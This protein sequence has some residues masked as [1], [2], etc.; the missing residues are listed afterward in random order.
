M[1]RFPFVFQPR[2]FTS[3]KSYSRADFL[4]DLAAGTTVAIIAL[5]LAMAFGIASGAGP[6]QG[7]AAAIIGGFL[8][9]ALGGSKVQIGGPAGAF[10][11]L[12]YSIV[13]QHGIANL[14]I[15][16]IM[17]GVLLFA[18]G[19]MRLGNLIRFIPVSVVIG[20]TAGIAVII[21][22]S[23]VKDALGLAIPKMPANFFSQLAAIGGALQ[24]LNWMAAAIALLSLLLITLWPVAYRSYSSSWQRLAAKFPSTLLVLV[25]SA[26]A[27]WALDLPVE[28]IGGK[29]GALP[30]GLSAPHIPAFDWSTAQNLV[31]P[32][33][34]I[35]L[36][37]AI[38]SLLCARMADG[39][40]GDRHDPNQELMAQGIAN[41]FSPWFGGIAVTGTAARTVTNIR[42]GARSP[43][44][45]VVHAFVLLLILLLFAP[46]AQYIPLASLAAILLWVAY[47]MGQWREFAKLGQFSVFY[48]TTLLST[49]F[50]TVVF[51]LVVA[52]EVGLVLSSLFFIYR[53]SSLTRVD[54]IALPSGSARLASGRRVGAWKLVGSLFF[55]SV[56]KLEALLEPG[57]TLPDVVI[58]EMDHLL[59]L[60]TTGLEALVSLHRALEMRGGRLIVA[61]AHEQPLSLM[62][63]GEF[64]KTVGEENFLPSLGAALSLLA[65]R[66]LP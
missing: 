60:D 9:S 3:L 66:D 22:L 43:V 52:V 27:A 46:L 42:T 57:R 30:R 37:A 6:A 5:P 8:V 47:N 15:A 32:T 7:L 33:L 65:N 62:Q 64:V 29:F 24:G 13:E 59:N 50:L 61:A 20:F 18:M 63:R 25:G 31:A 53:V 49:F 11:A 58:L 41:F 21:A 54:E 40:I 4:A 51:G 36:L 1:S 38:E 34:A 35:A 17:A 56:N 45:G 2:L 26:L 28:T 19:A 55:G 14:M 48:R 16:T 10:V 44:A 23:Q 12:L 39:L